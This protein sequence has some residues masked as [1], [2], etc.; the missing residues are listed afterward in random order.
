M[1]WEFEVNPKRSEEV[2]SKKYQF[3][4]KVQKGHHSENSFARVLSLVTYVER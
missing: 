4:E 1:M 2:G 3:L